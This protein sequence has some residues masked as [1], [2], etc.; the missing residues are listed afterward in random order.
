MDDGPK[1]KTFSSQRGQWT[2]HTRH[3]FHGGD[4]PE[5]AYDLDAGLHT[6]TISGRSKNFSLDRFH[7]YLEAKG[8]EALDPG[9][10]ESGA[11]APPVPDLKV[12][13]TAAACLQQGRLGPALADAERRLASKV[14]EEAA[15]ARRIVE[16]LGTYADKRRE[17]LLRLKASDPAMAASLLGDL[18]R[19]FGGTKRGSDLAAEA[20][21]W[22]ADPATR[23]AVQAHQV[24]AQIEQMAQPLLRRKA[25][26]N[27]DLAGRY[28]Q[29]LAAIG[30]AVGSLRKRYPETPACRK[31]LALASRL[32]ATVSE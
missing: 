19:Q 31:A 29:E 20:R 12:L 23:N 11:G 17:D 21:A 16:V 8:R 10:P 4:K 2:W 7:L 32:G 26:G 27:G 28:A 15:E 22:A 3:E 18:A 13:K 30:R 9:L 24:L 6:F 14:M 25:S 1:V 5:A